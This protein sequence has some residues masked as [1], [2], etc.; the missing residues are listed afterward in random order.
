VPA[1]IHLFYLGRNSYF[2]LRTGALNGFGKR[3]G[4]LQSPPLVLF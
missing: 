2:L 1:Y 4:A 3:A